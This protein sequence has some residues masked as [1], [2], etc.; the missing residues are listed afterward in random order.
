MMSRTGG[1]ADG[2]LRGPRLEFSIDYLPEGDRGEYLVDD[3]YSM[4]NVVRRTLRSGADWIKLCA[5]GGIASDYDDPLSAELT[6]GELRVG[7]TEAAARGK[8]VMVH[9]Y[10]G[11]GLDNCIRAGVKSIEH[12]TFLTEEQAAQMSVAGMWL[13][14]TVSILEDDIR[15]ARDGTV[16]PHIAA[17]AL[18]VEPPL[19]E[20]AGLA[21]AHGVRIAL[22]SD[23]VRRDLHGRNLAEIPA[24]ARS[25][26]PAA[27][28]LRAATVGGAE[29]LGIA[30]ERGGS[31]I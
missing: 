11:E 20:V 19:Y 18:T 23:A 10:G 14:P 1:H 22:G 16:A 29:L 4:R 21:H 30:D 5:T 8:H 25:G 27:E 28:C 26:L 13:V 15:C 12:G 24:L 6:E 9:A 7:V 31:L 17:K 3:E 2:F